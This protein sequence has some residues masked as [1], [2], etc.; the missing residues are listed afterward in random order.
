MAINQ[1]D[2]LITS[3]LIPV[4][5]PNEVIEVNPRLLLN[6]AAV[7]P[8]IVEPSGGIQWLGSTVDHWM[9][10]WNPDQVV[11]VEDVEWIAK[12][13]HSI[14]GNPLPISAHAQRESGVTPPTWYP[15]II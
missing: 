4:I 12:Y 9:I 7:S 5:G 2:M 11:P 13:I 1:D 14:E 15:V 6:S 10:L 8:H 3:G